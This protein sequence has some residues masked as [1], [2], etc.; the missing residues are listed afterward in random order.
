MGLTF[1]HLYGT[2]GREFDSQKSKN[3]NARGLPGGGGGGMLRLQIDRCIRYCKLYPY[4]TAT[5]YVQSLNCMWHFSHPT[6]TDER[7]ESE[8]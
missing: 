4:Q 3:S 7:K 1:E 5:T 6:G 8:T 2:G